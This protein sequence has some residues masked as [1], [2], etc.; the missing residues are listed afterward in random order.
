MEYEGEEQEEREEE[1][2]KKHWAF[3]LAKHII[4]LMGYFDAR[5]SQGFTWECT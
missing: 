2:K 5:R 3:V 1:R 4:Q